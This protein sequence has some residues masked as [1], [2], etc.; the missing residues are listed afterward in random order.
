MCG[1]LIGLCVDLG[2]TYSMLGYNIWGQESSGFSSLPMCH[3]WY[4]LANLSPKSFKFVR[5]WDHHLKEKQGFMHLVP[6]F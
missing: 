1:M 6:S 4:S 3:A 2:Q 5:E